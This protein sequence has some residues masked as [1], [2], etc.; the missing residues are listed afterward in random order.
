MKRDRTRRS[1]VRSD[2]LDAQTVASFGAEWSRFDQSRLSARE[3]EERFH[4]YFRVF[5]WER[6]PQEAEG[7]DAGCGTGRWA[8]HVLPRVG[9][10]HC[11]DPSGPAL[12][13]ARALL[14]D[15]ANKCEFHN[16]G[17]DDMP[18]ADCSMDFGYSLGVLHHVP[19]PAAGIRACVKKLRP[20]AP[21]LLYLYYA[22]EFRPRWYRAIFRVADAARRVVYGLPEP[23][24]I[25][26][27]T[28]IAAC[29][30]WPLSR[31]ARIVELAGIDPS[32]V[33]LAYYRRLSFYTLRT[34]ARDRFGT[35]VEHRFTREEV[36]RMM[37]EAGLRDIQVSD[38]P[39]FWCAVG[40]RQASAD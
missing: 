22:L 8:R 39:P 1:G 38:A 36:V 15:N 28:L 17:V 13:A 26:V 4:Q 32:G 11:V 31:I 30:Y 16:V 37:E 14:A 3:L 24:K 25:F 10:L 20:G 35:P 12:D 34:D 33:P 19:D 29:I 5:P 7:F 9:K 2:N 6:L 21:F 23:A 40:M 27:T 18:L